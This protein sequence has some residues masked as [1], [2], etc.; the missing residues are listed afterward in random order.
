MQCTYTRKRTLYK[1]GHREREN[2]PTCTGCSHVTV[3]LI[4]LFAAT[5]INC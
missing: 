5:L 4:Q 1:R 3:V 2:Y